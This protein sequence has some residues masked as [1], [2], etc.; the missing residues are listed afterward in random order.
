[1]ELKIFQKGFNYSQDGRGNRLVYHLQ[2]CN[3]F[4]PW[5]SNPEGLAVNGGNAID[6]NDLVEEV[7][8]CRAMFFDGGGVTLTGGEVTV[9]ICA[10][11]EFLSKL[12][13][14]GIHTCIET[15]GVSSRIPEL[16]L[17]LDQ[18]IMDVKHHN[19]EIHK[20]VTGQSCEETYKNIKA[21]V[22]FGFTPLLRIPLIGGFNASV[23]D[24]NA[25][26]KL[27]D[28]LGVKEKITLE[29]LRYHE[30]GRNKYDSLGLPYKMG[31]D[32]FVSSETARTIE[33]IFETHRYNIVHT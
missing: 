10:A 26:V 18:L 16:F 33:Q 11:K 28:N 3:L 25:F 21:A 31:K 9:Q 24:A 6:I 29:L 12:K 14:A 32:A 5:C 13:V 7:L 27:F 4:C 15:N 1:M 8:S 22:D 20:Q 17:Y 19:P 30:Y 2:G 23:G